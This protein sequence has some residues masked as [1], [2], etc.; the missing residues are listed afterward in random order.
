MS[1]PRGEST[2]TFQDR[3]DEALIEGWK[4]HRQ[5]EDRVELVKRKRASFFWH[6]VLVVLTSWWTLGLGNLLYW[7]KCR[8]ADSE[9]LTIIRED[10]GAVR[11]KRR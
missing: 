8:Y 9:F 1:Q 11:L 2:A 6:M 4:I 5:S 3:V 10:D 7:L